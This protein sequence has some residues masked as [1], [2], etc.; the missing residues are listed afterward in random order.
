MCQ[1]V[2]C[3]AAPALGCVGAVCGS[4]T[5]P[6]A[7]CALSVHAKWILQ[8]QPSP[9]HYQDLVPPIALCQSLTARAFIFSFLFPNR[10]IILHVVRFIILYIVL[11]GD[12]RP[13][14]QKSASPF[15]NM[16]PHLTLDAEKCL[17]MSSTTVRGF[18][19]G[20]VDF[21]LV[22]PRSPFVP[23]GSPEVVPHTRLFCGRV[24]ERSRHDPC[25]GQHIL[26]LWRPISTN[27]CTR[28]QSLP[29][30]CFRHLP[31]V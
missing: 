4:T 1:C 25:R 11:M 17:R 9:T 30:A 18:F 31:L 24:A 14:V 19:F 28:P 16:A 7:G 26:C 15:Q 12:R 5:C 20:F 10:S 8:R 3:I 6:R 23:D 22:F 21:L 27:S 29:C 2:A 13:K